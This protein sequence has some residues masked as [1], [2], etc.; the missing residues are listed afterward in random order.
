LFTPEI[1]IIAHISALY[2]ASLCPL[3]PSASVLELVAMVNKVNK[4]LYLQVSKK[5]SEM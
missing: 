4:A 2:G 1:D 5:I 3:M